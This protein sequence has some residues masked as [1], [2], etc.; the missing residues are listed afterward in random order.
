[1]KDNTILERIKEH[2]K[3]VALW[4]MVI[5]IAVPLIVYGLSEVSLLPVTGGNDWAGFWGGYFGALIG[6]ICTGVGVFL[7]IRYERE[8]GQDDAERAVLPYIALTT[9]EKE[10]KVDYSRLK[11]E[12]DIDDDEPDGYTE[13]LLNK[14]YF[15]IRGDKASPQKKLTK[16][17]RVLLENEG[18]RNEE[19]IEGTEVLTQQRV[20][21]GP[22]LLTNV[23]NGAAINFRVGFHLSNTKYNDKSV[24]YTVAKHLK[25]GADFYLNLF[26]E[27][28]D[29]YTEDKQFVL[30]IYYENI[31]DQKYLQEY[32]VLIKKG[33]LPK[34]DLG[35][36]Q[37]RINN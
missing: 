32:P 22:M 11:T 13:F 14:I 37:K 19:I 25:K 21:S 34:I 10:N 31:Y 7:S 23:G 4:S 29:E 2:K 28:L 17:Q 6:G 12:D 26:F 16:A 20:L 30:R 18:F 5:L 15:V 3:Q 9:L 33:K 1:M 36:K 35:Y 8:K 24:R 27:D